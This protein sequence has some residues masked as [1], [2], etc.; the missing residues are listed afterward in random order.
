ML[1]DDACYI[2]LTGLVA[3]KAL[4]VRPARLDH[5]KNIAFG[6]NGAGDA[7]VAE[8]GLLPEEVTVLVQF[9]E[10]TA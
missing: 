2:R 3:Y 7:Q 1:V 10:K 6:I 9:G 4:I 5:H 8:A